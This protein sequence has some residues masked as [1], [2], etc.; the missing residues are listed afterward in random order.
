[1]ISV[2]I[3][4]KSGKTEVVEMALCDYSKNLATLAAE[5]RLTGFEIIV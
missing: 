4:Y 1:M 3:T 2:K 5:G